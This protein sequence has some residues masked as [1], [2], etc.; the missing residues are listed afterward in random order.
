[1]YQLSKDQI[2]CKKAVIDWINSEKKKKYITIGGYAGTGKTTLIANISQAL[3][4]NSKKLKISFCSYTGKATQILKHNLYELKALNSKDTVST[5]HGLIYSPI[6]NSKEEIVGWQRKDELKTD[7]IIVDE[8]SMVNKQI[9]HDLTSFEVPVIAVGDHGQ[10]PPIEGEFNLMEKPDLKLEN[11]HRQA[12][13]N[14]IIKWSTVARNEGKIPIINERSKTGVIRKLPRDD[15]ESQAEVGEIL[16]S[17]NLNTMVLCGYN[18]TRVKLNQHIRAALGFVNPQPEVS[19]RVIC[20][21]NNHEKNIFNGMI[22]TIKEI[23]EE[24]NDWYFA[25]IDMHDEGDEY[26]GLISIKQFNNP[27][28]LNFTGKRSTIMRGDLFD[29]GYAMTVHKAQGSQAERV[30]L[31]EERFK[32]MSEDMWRKWLYTGITRA[33]KELYIIG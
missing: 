29:F 30:I 24:D 18:N 13:D 31:F 10:L 22:G 25:A 23:Y 21:R 4:K 15:Q 28:S 2:K 6:V 14:P 19:D 16:N 9:W 17:F 32:S 26:R 5:I 20:L 3:H 33:E 11:I 8:A 12:Q 27:S 1:M 7:L